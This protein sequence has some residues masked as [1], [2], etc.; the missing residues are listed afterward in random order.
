MKLIQKIARCHCRKITLLSTFIAISFILLI[1]AILQISKLVDHKNQRYKKS[2]TR[3]VKAGQDMKIIEK[4]CERYPPKAIVIG[5]TKC[6][7]GALTMFLNA[8][9]DIDNAPTKNAGKAV[10]FFDLHYKAGVNWYIRQMPCS[11]PDHVIVDHNPQYFRH[12]NVPRL[13]QKFNSTIKLILLVREPISRTVSQ[14]LQSS[15]GRR[16]TAPDVE[17]FLLDKSGKKIDTDN[18]AVS[19]S[20]YYIHVQKWLEF[21]PMDQFLLID[22]IELAKDPLN[23]LKQLEAFLGVRSY[24]NEDNVYYN[25]TRGFHCV[26]FSYS[27]RGYTCAG[28]SKGRVH[29]Q[30]TDRTYNLLKEHFDPLNEKLFKTI[31]KEFDWTTVKRQP[32]LSEK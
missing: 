19:A 17:T 25:A 3:Y 20:S 14:Y 28:S 1:S 24:F 31:G 22:T 12:E 10:N 4:A 18:F 21:F 23:P 6:G 27:D 2:T 5:V 15:G 32:T 30:L 29:P 11:K 16:A 8:H 13:I 9:P 26:K 7:T